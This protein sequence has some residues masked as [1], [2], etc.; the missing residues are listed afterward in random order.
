MILSSSRTVISFLF[1][2]SVVVVA[3]SPSSSS[4]SD[5]REAILAVL[6]ISESNTQTRGMAKKPKS[7][8]KGKNN[9]T[10]KDDD[11]G[12]QRFTVQARTSLI[13]NAGEEMDHLTPAESIFF[14]DTWMEAFQT[15]QEQAIDEEAEDNSNSVTVRSVIVEEDEKTQKKKKKSRGDDGRKLRGA[16]RELWWFY[17]FGGWF[18]VWAYIDVSCFLCGGSGYDDD[19]HYNDDDRNNNLMDRND[20]DDRYNNR[21]LT[22]FDGED[23]DFHHRFETMLCDMLREGPFE[24]FQQ[25]QDCEVTFPF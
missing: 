1:L 16:N 18:D 23:N 7:S 13:M 25:V 20:D 11:N 4:S 2:V 24:S 22:V 9:N 14:E 8:S 17:N 19:D 12:L 5:D 15:V 21:M 6:P 3:A 10:P